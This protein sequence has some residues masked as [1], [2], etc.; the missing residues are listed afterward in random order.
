MHVADW[1]LHAR[2]DLV[3]DVDEHRVVLARMRIVVPD[4]TDVES[5]LGLGVDP[6]CKRGD[7][8]GHL[9]ERP[10]E[11]LVDRCIKCLRPPQPLLMLG[12][13]R[14]V[15]L[16]RHVRGRHRSD[17]PLNLSQ[18]RLAREW[19]Q[20]LGRES[21]KKRRCAGTGQGYWNRAS[22]RNWP[23]SQRST[24]SRY[25]RMAVSANP[26]GPNLICDTSTPGFG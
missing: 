5:E 16:D 26:Y 1:S 20:Y 14:N 17:Q 22:W 10:V 4:G 7:G 23:R 18:Q 21:D 13:H 3:D 25:E 24:N 12:F 15:E 9:L 8:L 6:I 11:F 2:D 19:Q